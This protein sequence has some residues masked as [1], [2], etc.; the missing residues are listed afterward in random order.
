MPG[1]ASLKLVPNSQFNKNELLKIHNL[2]QNKLEGTVDL[3]T[4]IVDDIPLTISGKFKF[5]D[6][7]LDISDY[8]TKI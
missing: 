1:K 5:I 6:Q 4:M 3:N 7:K 2:M 8:L